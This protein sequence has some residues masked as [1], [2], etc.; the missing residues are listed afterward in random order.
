MPNVAKG[1]VIVAPHT[2]NWDFF[3][4]ITAMFA[5]GVRFSWLGKCIV[6][7]QPLGILMR[8]LG[9]IPV[10]RSAPSGVVDQ[11]IQSI[12]EA[13]TM[14]LALSP[15]GTRKTTSRWR[16]G[17]WHI[18]RGSRVP[19]IPVYFDFHERIIGLTPVFEPGDEIAHDLEVLQRRYHDVTPRHS[20]P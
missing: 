4:G 17:F 5:L 19:I 20:Y 6:F 15:E 16:S 9:G 13:D 11:V 10:D 2:S 8:W 3:V 7:R 18:A 12:T 1:V 14:L